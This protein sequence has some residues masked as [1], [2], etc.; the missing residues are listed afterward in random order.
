MKGTAH[1]V[2]KLVHG[3]DAASLSAAETLSAAIDTL[4][5]DEAF[6]IGNFGVAAANAESD[7]TVLECDTSGGSYA[8]V[9]DAAISQVT[10]ANDQTSYGLRLD[11]R[12]RKR[13][14]K[15][16]NAGDASN[17]VLLAV[18]VLLMSPTRVPVTQVNTA[19][20]V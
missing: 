5:F 16:K 12:K 8:A 4:G 3:L 19:V 15:I 6:V 13:Y 2:A 7:V 14:L 10:A 20:S 11:L 17:A 18:S 1:E 9:T